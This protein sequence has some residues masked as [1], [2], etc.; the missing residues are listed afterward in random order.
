[1]KTTNLQINKELI[2]KLLEDLEKDRMLEEYY[3]FTDSN[4]EKEVDTMLDDELKEMTIVDLIIQ[5]SEL[6]KKIDMMLLQYEYMRKELIKRR[7]QLEQHDEFK[8]KQK[9]I[10]L[11]GNDEKNKN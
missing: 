11:G 6:N 2:D 9:R 8:P 10:G 4:E 5:M 7:P 1:M 3:S